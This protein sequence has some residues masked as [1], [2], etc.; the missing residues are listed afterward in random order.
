METGQR[1]GDTK[2]TGQTS[3]RPREVDTSTS[4]FGGRGVGGLVLQNLTSKERCV[5]TV[6][7]IGARRVLQLVRQQNDRG[8]R[9]VD[10]KIAQ[11]VARGTRHILF[12]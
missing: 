5:Q 11:R 1:G 7:D 12:D 2:G 6:Q 10:G 3:G 8:G 4:G 9:S